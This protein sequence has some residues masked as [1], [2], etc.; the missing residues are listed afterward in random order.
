MGGDAVKLEAA[1]VVGEARPEVDAVGIARM[2]RENGVDVAKET[3][4][5][6]VNLSAAA[7]FSRRSVIPDGPFEAARLHLFFD[8]DRGQR[9]QT[10]L[11]SVSPLHPPHKAAATPSS[12]TSV[13][14]FKLQQ[15]LIVP[16]R[17][18]DDKL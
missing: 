12:R 1:A 2:P 9:G 4:V 5:Q 8:G 18:R 16:I 7:F 15:E 14:L 10:L 3:G 6:H 17:R 11:P 13:N